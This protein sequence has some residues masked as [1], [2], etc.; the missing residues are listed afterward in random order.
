MLDASPCAARIIGPMIKALLC[1]IDGTLV[2]SNW[3][4][5]EAW[6][7]ALGAIG[8]HLPLEELRRQIGKGGDQLVPTF[9]P[10]WKQPHVQHPLEEF[11]K[12]VFQSEYLSQVKPIPRVREFLLRLKEAGIR[13]SLASSASTEDLATYKK[14]ASIEDLIEEESS[15]D[16]AK[17][18]KPHPDIFEATLRRL[19]LKA[20]EVLAL[21]DTPYDAEAAGK[22]GVWTIGVMTGGWTR[23]E[24]LNAG[25]IEVYEDVGEL[26]DR[27]EESAL[28]RHD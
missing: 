15:K 28:A 7:V 22:A 24:L 25:C 14:I 11:R 1:D 13:L 12:F 27:F 20:N 9:V 6:Q 23:E 16:D 21:G 17:Q 5:A 3:L 4:H 10:W 2:Q 18:S 26:L 19:G 8:V